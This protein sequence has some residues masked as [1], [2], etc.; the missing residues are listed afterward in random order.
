MK[1]KYLKREGEREI[2]NT[3]L[4]YTFFS[5]FDGGLFVFNDL[6]TKKQKSIHLFF[7]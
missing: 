7:F 2:L 6:F 5:G 3:K 4:S 1:K